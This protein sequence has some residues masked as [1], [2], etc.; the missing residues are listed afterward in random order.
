MSP[1]DQAHQYPGCDID[2]RSD[3]SPQR[4][5]K[6]ILLTNLDRLSPRNANKYQSSKMFKQ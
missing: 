2:I 4:N 3:E 6:S 5:Y 1:A